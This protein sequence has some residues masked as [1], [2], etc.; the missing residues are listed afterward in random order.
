MHLTLISD[1]IFEEI[2]GIQICY[3][4]PAALNTKVVS[5]K[6]QRA[7][8]LIVWNPNGP[9]WQPYNLVKVSQ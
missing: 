5:E 1:I 4:E 7:Y 3:R 9:E 6:T 8:M 2:D